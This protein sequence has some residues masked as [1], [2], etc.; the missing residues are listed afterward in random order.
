MLK[1]FLFPGAD[2]FFEIISKRDEKGSVIITTNK[3]FESWGDI[4]ADP[5]TGI[6]NN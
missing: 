4:F 3:S 6:S 2:N 5:V 1:I